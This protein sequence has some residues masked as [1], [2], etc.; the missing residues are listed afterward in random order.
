MDDNAWIDFYRAYG[1]DRKPVMVCGSSTDLPTQRV[2]YVNT[3]GIMYHAKEYY[4]TYG[5]LPAS[6]YLYGNLVV[7]PI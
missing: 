7:F 5:K 4:E 2:E 3:Q 1:Q 6:T